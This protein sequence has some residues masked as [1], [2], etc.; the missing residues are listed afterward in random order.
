MEYERNPDY[1]KEGLP[2]IDGMKHFIITDSGR[3]IAA[4]KTG[5][6]LLRNQNGYILSKA[7]A[8]QLDK[9][10]DNI[11]VFWG[12]AEFARYVMMNVEK[13]PFDK[14]EVR[15]AVH[16]A[17]DRQAILDATGAGKVWR[18]P[19]LRASGI[20]GTMRRTPI[21]PAIGTLAEKKTLPT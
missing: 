7:E 21:C 19:C 11:T 18:I 12:P 1:W 13:A 3:L 15:K 8:L 14:A 20:A 6:V 5:Q 4:Y 10:Q 16:L 17:I 2:N 9:D